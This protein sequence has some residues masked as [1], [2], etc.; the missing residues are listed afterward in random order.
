MP[1][2]NRAEIVQTLAQ[3]SSVWTKRDQT[4]KIGKYK[5]NKPDA[6]QQGRSGRRRISSRSVLKS[7]RITGSLT[8]PAAE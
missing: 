3:N 4:I 1:S 6:V 2:K 5:K 7:R 8:L